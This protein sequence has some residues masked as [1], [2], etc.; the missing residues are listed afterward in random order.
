M[1]WLKAK[2]FQIG[3]GEIN[4]LVKA[5]ATL[6]VDHRMSALNLIPSL[7]P[8]IQTLALAHREDSVEFSGQRVLG[9][10]WC[11]A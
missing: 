1:Q 4:D 3:Q 11:T 8:M 7:K 6:Q 5:D 9:L 2:R 10:Y